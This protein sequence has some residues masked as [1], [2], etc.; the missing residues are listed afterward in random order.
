MVIKKEKNWLIL[1]NGGK[2]HNVWSLED[3][4]AI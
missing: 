2:K 4:L 3:P 1:H